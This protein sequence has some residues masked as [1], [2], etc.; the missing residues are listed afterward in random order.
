MKDYGITFDVSKNSLYKS[1]AGEDIYVEDEDGKVY[2]YNKH[3]KRTMPLKKFTNVILIIDRENLKD[4]LKN[5]EKI[6][7]IEDI[8]MN[9][10]KEAR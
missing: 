10:W 6:A 7:Q 3:T 4:K 8:A 1:D 5:P 9:R 2:T